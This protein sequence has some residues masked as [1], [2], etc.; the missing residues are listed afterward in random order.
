LA[1]VGFLIGASPWLLYTAQHG[2]ITLREAAGGAVAGASNRHLLVAAFEHLVYLGLFGIT[3]VWGLRPPW[4]ASFLALPLVPYALAI[5][6]GCWLQALRRT[7]AGPGRLLLAGTAITLIVAFILTPFGADPSGRYFLPLVVIS[8]LYLADVLHWLRLRRRHRRTVWRKWFAQILALGVVAFY[9][10]GNV[11]S[12]ARYPPGITTQFD[13]VAQVDGRALD[14]LAT[15]L[16]VNG[17]SRGYT[18]YWVAYPL[19]FVSQEA[20]LFQPRLPYH[21][22]FRYTPRDDRY[23]PYGEAVAESPRVAYITA[24]HP[25]LDERLRRGLGRL[26]VPYQEAAIGDYRVFFALGRRVEPAELGLGECCE[27]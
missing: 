2:A 23:A 16:Q 20:L 3:V 26:G 24:R 15:F 25:A 27:P 1:L 19:A 12:A 22:D 7:T 8:A 6:M 17:E 21:L 5:H 11:Q 10:W 14:D 4:S 9:W 18:N 13:A